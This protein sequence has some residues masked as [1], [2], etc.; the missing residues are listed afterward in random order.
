MGARQKQLHE[1]GTG[2]DV[3]EEGDPY[4]LLWDLWLHCLTSAQHGF[5]AAC[6]WGWKL[7]HKPVEIVV[8]SQGLMRAGC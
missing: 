4:L 8:S 6:M 1:H 3:N 5:P 7:S 2:R